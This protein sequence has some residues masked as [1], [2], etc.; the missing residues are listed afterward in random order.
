MSVTLQLCGKQT[1]NYLSSLPWDWSEIFFRSDWAKNLKTVQTRSIPRGALRFATQLLIN[2]I[3][4][5]PYSHM[6]QDAGF[7]GYLLN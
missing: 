2:I 7:L 4:M 1:P 5:S 3:F 6:K